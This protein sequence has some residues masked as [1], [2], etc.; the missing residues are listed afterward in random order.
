MNS[1][2][3]AKGRY[4]IKKNSV[5]T[6]PFEYG[7][8]LARLEDGSLLPSELVCFATK[9]RRPGREK[10]FPAAWLRQFPAWGDFRLSRTGRI[11][12]GLL[13]ANVIALII[14]RLLHK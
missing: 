4:L 10:W 5:E 9:W 7:Q 8:I 13:A 14:Y 12:W 6:G 11:V 2:R 3:F 1:N